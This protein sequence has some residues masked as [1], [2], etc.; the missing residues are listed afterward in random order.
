MQLFKEFFEKGLGIKHRHRGTGFTDTQSS[1]RRKKLNLVPDWV[2]PDMT[3][4]QKIENLKKNKGSCVCAPNDLQYIQS[5][6]NIIPR[7]D[8]ACMLGKTGIELFFNTQNN[9]FMLR[10]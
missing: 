7:K 10:K 2:K 1:Y 8:K 4:N 5:T 9:S 3:K 6:F